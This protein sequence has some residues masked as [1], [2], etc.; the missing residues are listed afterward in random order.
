MKKC[1]IRAIDRT[2]ELVNV[3]NKQREQFIKDCKEFVKN[4]QIT[5]YG[6]INFNPREFLDTVI[7]D[8]PSI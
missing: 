3:C 2:I 7:D 1:G 4:A 6:I 5:D 8:H